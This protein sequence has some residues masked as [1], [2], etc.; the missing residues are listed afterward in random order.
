MSN[1]S[2][3]ALSERMVLAK[4][5]AAN[6]NR[7]ACRNL[8]G[9][10]DHE[11]LRR[12]LKKQLKE[13]QASDCQRWNFDFKTETPLKGRFL[14]ETLDG[15][16]MPTFYRETRLAQ[17]GPGTAQQAK[18][19]SSFRSLPKDRQEDKQ[20]GAERL[21]P[22]IKGNEENQ[23]EQIVG[24]KMGRMDI[25]RSQS[26]VRISDFFPKRKRTGAGKVLGE[27]AEVSFPGLPAEQTSRRRI[28]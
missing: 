27:S 19:L 14:W 23:R 5:Q 18:E 24:S 28:R 2:S 10:I 22:D 26:P 15:K 8:F 21:R 7:S 4:R 13:I 6:L 20:T 25:R 16:E 11:E 17:G 3:M 9:A 12:D 1:F